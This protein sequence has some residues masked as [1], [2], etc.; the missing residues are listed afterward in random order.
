MNGFSQE[1]VLGAFENP[2]ERLQIKFTPYLEEVVKVE[3]G[4]KAVKIMDEEALK[5]AE[6]PTSNDDEMEI[7]GKSKGKKVE[8][9]GSGDE[10]DELC[11]NDLKVTKVTKK[12]KARANKA[13]KKLAAIEVSSDDSDS[14]SS[15]S[16]D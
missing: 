6:E 3:R 9:E 16:D 11:S 10:S 4:I 15:D 8:S 2:W 13:I 14:D 5:C 7:R 1:D 12:K